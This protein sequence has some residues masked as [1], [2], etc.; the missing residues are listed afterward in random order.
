MAAP[1]SN[2]DY[3]RLPEA[4]RLVGVRK[5]QLIESIEAGKLIPVIVDG[6]PA[7]RPGD[8]LNS[9][10]KDQRPEYKKFAHL[11]GNA[12]GIAEAARKYELKHQTL[13]N[14]VKRGHVKQ[15]GRDPNHAQ[16]ILVDEADVA[17]CA[18]IQKQRPGAGRWTL[19]QDHT[20]YTPKAAAA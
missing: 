18:E 20:P 17:Y 16:K 10:P 6:K 14:W 4:A 1:S 7:V 5:S 11:R 13:S 15:L 3:L 12:L 9:L 19:G 2:E 8:V